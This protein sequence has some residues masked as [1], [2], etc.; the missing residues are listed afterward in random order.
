MLLMSA[1][2]QRAASKKDTASRFAEYRSLKASGRKRI[3]NYQATEEEDIYE[4]V[5]EDGYKKVVRERL[6][7]DDFVVDD[8]GLGYADNGMDDWQQNNYDSED[9][10]PE[11][12]SKA[13]GKS[14][15]LSKKTEEVPANDKISKYLS[16]SSLMT[17]VAKT[18]RP[19]AHTQSSTTDV[20]DYNRTRQ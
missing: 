8:N 1:R 17:P 14:T 16:K 9:E 19:V 4:E 12:R 6:D 2:A 11:H 13:R 10:E 5:D 18:V 20:E 3:D 7:Q 15:K